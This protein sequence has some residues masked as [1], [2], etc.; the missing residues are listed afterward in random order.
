[1]LALYFVW[2]RRKQLAMA[3]V[4]LAWW[5]LPALV[6]MVLISLYGL[7]G[8]SGNVSRPA[9]PFLIILFTLFC[10]GFQFARGMALPLLIL[11][12]IVPIPDSLERSLGVWLKLISSK[13]TVLMLRM[14]RTSVFL[15]G[16]VLDLGVTQLQVLDA[17]SGLRFLFPLIA[18]G[19]AYAAIS[20]KVFWEQVICVAA[21]IPIAVL[22]NRVRIGITGILTTRSGGRVTN[23][24]G[25]IS[26]R[27]SC[28]W[29]HLEW[30]S[31]REGFFDFFHQRPDSQDPCRRWM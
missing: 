11:T 31:F 6:L 16:N 13:L 18:L 22:T 27:G 20:E 15:S 28:S 24:G 5:A 25:T 21:T 14:C 29:L 4:A 26:L 1:V 23:E 7:L 8:S 19:I 3:P 2:A 17:C 9:I 10:F 12:F 30:S